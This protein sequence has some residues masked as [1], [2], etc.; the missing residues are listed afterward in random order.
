[1]VTTTDWADFDPALLRQSRPMRVEAGRL[2]L[3]APRDG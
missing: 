3:A 1:V 2:T